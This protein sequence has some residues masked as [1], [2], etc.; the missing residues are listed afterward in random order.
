M[1]GADKFAQFIDTELKPFINSK[2]RATDD[3]TL[4]G[5]SFGGLFALHVLFNRNAVFD[6]YLI[7]SPSMDWDGD[8]GFASRIARLSARFTSQMRATQSLSLPRN[9]GSIPVP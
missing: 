4:V 3:S 5:Y 9:R 7:G 8:A 6:R 2:Y 1:R